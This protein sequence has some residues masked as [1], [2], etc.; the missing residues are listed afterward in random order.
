[1]LGFRDSRGGTLQQVPL[2][3]LF[4]A[5]LFSAGVQAASPKFDHKRLAERA[6]TNFI[7]PGYQAL[8]T[9]LGKLNGALQNLCQ[10]P[11]RA[12]VKSTHRLFAQVVSAWGRIENIR[13]GPVVAKNRF[14]RIFYWPDRKGRGARQVRRLLA[15][16]D[17]LA[18]RSG[19]LTKK[20]VAVQGLSALEIALFGKNSDKLAVDITYR[21]RYALAIVQN[22]SDVTTEII[23]AW[24]RDGAFEKVWRSA[25]E[26]GNQV[27]LKSSEVTLD[28]VGAFDNGLQNLYDL[29]LAPMAGLGKI[30]K[31]R[32]R[33]PLW[34]SRT[35]MALIDANLKGLE[36]L[37]FESGL[38]EVYIASSRQRLGREADLLA[39]ARDEFQ[40]TRKVA[41]RLT[42]SF[43]KLTPP[44]QRAAI[45]PL[46]FA[47][48]NIRRNIVGE[49]K[50]AAGL[51]LG[52]NA[53]DGD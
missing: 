12:R 46:A 22:L 50:A 41:K 30:T 51:S 37:L 20:S 29:R 7:L 16:K 13:F 17:E 53:S 5:L 14:E 31:Q 42:I 43:S 9:E 32:L 28:I 21:C 47:A 11:S 45:V 27:Y 8:N 26:A 38:S 10:H 1:M 34:R 39:S 49:I 18:L 25:G 19:G 3:L 4:A 48:A 33:P 15:A 6:R 52:F 35:T 44:D 40:L 36:D 24:S 23:S 2:L